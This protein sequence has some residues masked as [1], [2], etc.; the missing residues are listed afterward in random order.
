MK[1][2]LLQ[3]EIIFDIRIPER[4]YNIPPE[5][6]SNSRAK[7]AQLRQQPAE[8]NK[9]VFALL[10]LNRFIGENPFV[11]EAGGI[12]TET[13]ARQSVSKILSQQLNNLASDLI[14]GVDLEFDLESSA[15]YSTGQPENRT[16][17]NVGLSKQLLNDRL[18]VT[19]GSSFE[20]EGSQ[21]NNENANNIAGDIMVDYLL[22]KDGRYS[23]QVFR[24]NEYQV[25]LQGQIIETGVAFIITMEYDT[26]KEF[27]QRKPNE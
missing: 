13:F 26:F 21:N 4:N 10:I 15:A 9:Q 5:V 23:I 24:K 8:L 27:F 11:S 1:G 2:T 16:D 19:I 17:L 18:K 12:N 25:A 7:L 20:L 3:P 22:S 6:L 14:A